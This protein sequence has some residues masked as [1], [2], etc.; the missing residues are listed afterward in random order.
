[1]IFWPHKGDLSKPP[2]AKDLRYRRPTDT[3][4]Y[5]ESNSSDKETARGTFWKRWHRET[6]LPYPPGPFPRAPGNRKPEFLNRA[7]TPLRTSFTPRRD[8]PRGVTSLTS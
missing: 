8:P 6:Q 2:E 7:G 1:M 4:L 5:W 3:A